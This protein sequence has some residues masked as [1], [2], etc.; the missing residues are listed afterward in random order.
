MALLFPAAFI[1]RRVSGAAALTSSIASSS[2]LSLAPAFP[3]AVAARSFITSPRSLQQQVGGSSSSSSSGTNDANGAKT[4]PTNSSSSQ[5][6]ATS[7]RTSPLGK[8]HYAV[9]I[10][11]A[12]ALAQRE[13]SAAASRTGSSSADREAV[14]QNRKAAVAESAGSAAEGGEEGA[15]AAD[16]DEGAGEGEGDSTGATSS[17]STTSGANAES[18]R[19]AAAAPPKPYR[20]YHGQLISPSSFNPLPQAGSSA[21]PGDDADSTDT[22]A[23]RRPRAR[24]L[25]GPSAAVAK[26]LDPFY[27]LGLNPSKPSLTDDSYKN[28]SLL[29]PFVSDLGRILPRNRTGLTRKSQRQVGKAIRRARAM[30]IRPVFSR[31]SGRSTGYIWK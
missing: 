23:Q 27:K 24:P 6:S 10:P 21:A 22:A 8:E 13:G 17:A 29:I 4:G 18:Q 7:K 31:G 26:R 28:G 3:S 12:R 19:R 25:L 15:E 30:G 9:Q 20:F 14:R 11:S 16:E 2:R 1:A 5:Q